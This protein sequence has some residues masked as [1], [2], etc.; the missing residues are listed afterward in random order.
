MCRQVICIRIASELHRYSATAV[1]T[2]PLPMQP[3]VTA[4]FTGLT[5][6]SSNQ[7]DYVAM[8]AQTQSARADVGDA[9][10]DVL[11]AIGK[12]LVQ[13][14]AIAIGTCLGIILFL[15]VAREYAGDKLDDVNLRYLDPSSTS[16]PSG[17]GD[18]FG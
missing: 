9:F 8:T 17:V 11:A 12:W 16:S 10:F 7:R 6:L 3:L 4:C 2:Y 13:V 18:T 5:P 1:G 14:A 15:M